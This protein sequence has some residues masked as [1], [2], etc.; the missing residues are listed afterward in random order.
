[1]TKKLDGAEV[2]G[3]VVLLENSADAFVADV[4]IKDKRLIPLGKG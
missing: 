4:C 3:V 1:M 2:S